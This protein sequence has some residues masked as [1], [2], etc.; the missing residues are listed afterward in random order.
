MEWLQKSARWHAART[1]RRLTKVSVPAVCVCVC[2]CECASELSSEL[3]S[4]M[5]TAHFVI[6]SNWKIYIEGRRK[7]KCIIC[8]YFSFFSLSTHICCAQ[9][10]RLRIILYGY[11]I[12]IWRYRCRTSFVCATFMEKLDFYFCRRAAFRAYTRRKRAFGKWALAPCIS[13]YKL[14]VTISVY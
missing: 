6:L 13:R 2:A 11:F 14:R 3:D 1:C 4:W 7:W 10:T 5:R 8:F 9:V 12:Y